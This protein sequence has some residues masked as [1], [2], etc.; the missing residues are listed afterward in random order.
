MPPES[1]KTP[2][3]NAEIRI[4]RDKWGIP[5][6]FA[7]SNLDVFFG[8]GYC[9]AED[10]LFQIEMTRRSARGSMAEVLGERSIEAD[11]RTRIMGTHLE[12]LRKAKA[13]EG[14][15]RELLGAFAEGANAYIRNHD[16]AQRQ[17]FREL[18]FAP[19][20]WTVEDVIACSEVVGHFET[21]GHTGYRL[22]EKVGLEMARECYPVWP[23]DTPAIVPEFEMAKNREVYER[24]RNVVIPKPRRPATIEERSATGS[25]NCLV[26]GSKSATGMPILFGDPQR[27]PRIPPYYY[28]VALH[29]GDFH[30]R[31]VGFAG[32]PGLM[33]GF[34]RHCA[35][36]GTGLGADRTDLYEEKLHPDNPDLYLYKG[37]WYPVR[38]RT[39]VI[40]V[41]GGEDV[42]LEVRS[43]HHGTICGELFGEKDRHLAF[44]HPTFE[45]TDTAVLGTIRIN[46]AK[47]YEE[48]RDAIS[49]WEALGANI[50][51]A[52]VE[53]NTGY[54]PTGIVPIR[55]KGRFWGPVPGWTG[56]YEWGGR[57][58]F[59]ERPS[60]HNPD[61]DFIV[62][63]NNLVVSDWYPYTFVRRPSTGPRF[64]RLREAIMEKDKFDRSDMAKLRSDIKCTPETRALLPI[65]LDVLEDAEDVSDE[66]REAAELL[67]QWDFRFSRDSVAATIFDRFVRELPVAAARQHLGDDYQLATLDVFRLAPD[68]SWYDDPSTLEVETRSDHFVKVFRKI[69][70]KLTEKLGSDKSKWAWGNVS[71]T[72]IV[73]LVEE[74][75]LEDRIEVPDYGEFLME[76]SKALTPHVLMVV[77]Y[78]QVVDLTDMDKT[79]AVLSVG[80]SELYTSPHSHDQVELWSNWQLR[81]AFLGE[82]K[83]K[84]VSCLTT[85]LAAPH[86]S[87]RSR[88]DRPR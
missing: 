63:A 10:R 85:V 61:Q 50:I 79:R 52:D 12:A 82:D 3:I 88:R 80:N 22:V 23:D 51:Y 53:G 19:E 8:W 62:T 67:R 58:P 34:N 73:H 20:P 29:G 81:P 7:G 45:T 57:I 30:C 65:L 55:P 56:E 72:R 9:T 49:K 37:N 44:R 76:G 70:A 18:G 39:E 11:R 60:L 46:V 25:N 47:S 78:S 71:K 14:Y 42:A 59:E 41:K 86:G 48:F 31:G 77:T 33:H 38:K 26:T 4:Y 28:E 15:F 83:L 6:I 66:M 69:L 16:V 84:E 75:G 35:W 74:L 13:L 54:W 87:A 27:C 17:G 43:T 5:A 2:G 32:V 1:L 68:S 64:M 21:F 36:A 40:K 24:L